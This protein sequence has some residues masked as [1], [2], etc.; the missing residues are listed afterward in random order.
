MPSSVE[1]FAKKIREMRLKK[2]LSQGDL[3]K[4]LGVHRTYISSMERG[5]R[6]PSLLTIEK[7]ARAFRLK[8][9]ELFR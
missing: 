9:K 7:F 5:L 3:A 6:N 1:E 2:N 8:P 4:A